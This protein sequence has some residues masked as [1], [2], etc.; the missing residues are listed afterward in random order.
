MNLTPSL[1]VMNNFEKSYPLLDLSQIDMLLESGSSESIELFAE[2]L[3]LFENE[4]RI[5]L[6]DLA[7]AKARE[8]S[9]A[10][11]NA[12]H[13]LA[14]SSA[15]IGGKSVWLKARD[16]ENLSKNN[17][18]GEAFAMLTGLETDFEETLA[19]LKSYLDQVSSR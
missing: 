12:A 5:K 14:G 11:S 4:S 17:Q 2:I 13:A 19:Q 15:N 1:L 8:N 3:V 6:Q 16:M 10:F 18:S 9:E 7:D